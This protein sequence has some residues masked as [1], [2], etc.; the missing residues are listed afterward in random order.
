[1]F[2]ADDNGTD[3]EV[4]E[5]NCDF[6]LRIKGDSMEPQIP[7]GS[8]VLI[9]K[10]ETI[11]TGEIGAFFHNGTVYCKKRGTNEG[12][13]LLIS[14]NPKYEP[15]EVVE[16]DVSKCYGKVISILS[17]VKLLSPSEQ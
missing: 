17:P 10:Q 14:N 5:G 6:A 7:N 9:H 8:I 13:T 3:F 1:M 15:I 2:E 4:S 16:D 11:E 12:K